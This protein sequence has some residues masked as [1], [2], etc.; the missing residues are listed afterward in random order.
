LIVPLSA[1]DYF[2]TSGTTITAQVAIAKKKAN[3]TAALPKSFAFLDKG[4]L[5]KET[6]STTASIAE[7][8]NSIINTKIL[9]YG[10]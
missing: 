5:S 2:I 6:R 3:I 8:N 7:F 9:C 4:F 10:I 1:A